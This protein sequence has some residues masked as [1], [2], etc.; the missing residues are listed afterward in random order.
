MYLV[1]KYKSKIST[2]TKKEYNT[3]KSFSF[4]NNM[5]PETSQ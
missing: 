5:C 1:K 2:E 3:K 4:R